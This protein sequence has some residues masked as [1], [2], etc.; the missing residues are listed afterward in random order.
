[1]LIKIDLMLYINNNTIS[2]KRKVNGSMT[3]PFGF[4]LLLVYNLVISR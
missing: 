3:E 1:M 2:D 4:W